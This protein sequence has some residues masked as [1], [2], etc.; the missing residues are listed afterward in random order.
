MN[1]GFLTRDVRISPRNFAAVT[2]L[3]S[4]TLAWFFLLILYLPRSPLGGNYISQLLFVCSAIFWSVVGSFF[5]MRFSRRALLISSIFLGT[6]STMILAFVQ[7]TI[8]EVACLLLGTSLG[9]GLPSS[10]AILA[11]YTAV[12]ERGRV[13]GIVVLT[14]FIIA[15][16]SMA[17]IRIFSL[18]T[19]GIA[20]L[21]TFVR[22]SSLLALVINKCE[23]LV[24]SVKE[25][26]HLPVAANR[27]FLFY[28]FPWVMFSIASSLAWNAIP[29][30]TYAAELEPLTTLRY[31][32]IA[33]FGLAAGVIADRFGRKRVIIIGLIVLGVAF[34]MIGLSL[35]NTG[36]IWLHR[37]WYVYLA[38][39]GVTWGSFFVVFLTVP[40]DLSDANS[41]E[42]FYA[43]V[44]GLFCVGAIP[45]P[46][47]SG[48][49]PVN[50]LSQ[51]LSI[52]LFLSIVPVLRAKET[53]QERKIQERKM[54]EHI[55]KI[56][57]I[58][59]QSEEKDHAKEKS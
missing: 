24:T 28:I 39:S 2:V 40:G 37:L 53:L 19:F 46:D 51:I 9:L 59:K 43:L 21:F 23:R 15:F 58:I 33:I 27:D 32:F 47:F 20:L 6:I 10:M 30:Q 14:T 55:E 18:A 1:L 44:A 4:G 26:I 49:L 31:V 29:Q 42:K 5:P 7:G 12:E 11:D 38:L 3:N 8:F 41:R 34:A 36:V 16:A 45:V 17:L 52:I 25:K 35:G 57:K 56:G 50:S 48:V 22:S 13:S 54:Q